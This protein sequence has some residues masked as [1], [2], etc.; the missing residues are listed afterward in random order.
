MIKILI[1]EDD[2]ALLKGFQYTL[3]KEGFEVLIAK[4][5]KEARNLIKDDI[6]L[7]LLDV[8]LPDGNGFDFCSE[9]RGTWNTPII[10]VTAC[11]EEV[12]IV[13]GLDL[14]GDDYITKPVRVN[15]LISRINAVIRRHFKI[16]P[17]NNMP[18]KKIISNDIIVEPLRFKVFL[19]NEEIFL[20]SLE[21]K[22]LLLFIENKGNVLSREILL[23]RLWDSEGN[24]VDGN[25]LNVYVKRIREKIEDNIKEPKY[26]ETVRGIGYRWRA[27]VRGND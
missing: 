9:I 3:K 6:N 13:L 26:I 1:V 8:T 10:F 21:Y 15:E 5:L 18:T 22:I 12:N 4:N 11:D 17:I 24:F 14:G 7:I 23:D 20:T 27:E 19:R 16:S 2:L 25:T